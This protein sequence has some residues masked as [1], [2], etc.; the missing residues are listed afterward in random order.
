L[1]R[2]CE[3]RYV[4]GV[5]RLIPGI[6]ILL[7]YAIT[8]GAGEM[9]E[10]IAH[11]V[12]D[13]H[14]AHAQ[15]QAEEAQSKDAHGCS[16]P[17]QTCPCHGTSAFVVDRGPIEVSVAQLGVETLRWFVASLEADGVMTGVFRPP[18]A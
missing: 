15:H 5:H 2:L 11:F 13:G 16:G 9:T 10:N 6:A 7:A 8:P 12:L 1:A 4:G 14:G 17:F 18:I 3:E